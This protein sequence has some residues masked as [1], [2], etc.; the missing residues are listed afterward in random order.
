[1][2]GG[3]FSA[4]HAEFQASRRRSAS[5]AAAIAADAASAC[6][7]PSHGKI[8]STPSPTNFKTSPPRAWT[9]SVMRSK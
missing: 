2:S 5:V 9:G 8:A 4:R 3:S 7:S 6:L 1:L